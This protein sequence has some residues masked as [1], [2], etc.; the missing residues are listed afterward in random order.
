MIPIS[1]IAALTKV[2]QLAVKSVAVVVTTLGRTLGSGVGIFITS[3]PRQIRF[4]ERVI[5]LRT[6]ARRI[7]TKIPNQ[8]AISTLWT[9]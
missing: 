4:T 2:D 8:S 1:A 3:F 5:H 6:T 7:T 9:N